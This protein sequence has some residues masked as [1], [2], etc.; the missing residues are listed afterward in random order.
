MVEWSYSEISFDDPDQHGRQAQNLKSGMKIENKIF[1]SETS[2]PILAQLD[3]NDHWL[4]A[5]KKFVL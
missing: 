2:K 1:S 3:R 5:F 4:V